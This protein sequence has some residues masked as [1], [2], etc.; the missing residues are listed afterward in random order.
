MIYFDNA[1]T[2][3]PH[4]SVISAAL[5]MMK[6]DFGN[7][8]SLHRMGLIAEDELKR[9]RAVIAKEMGASASEV[10]FTSGGTEG[11]NIAILGGARAKKRLGNTVIIPAT[12]HASVENSALSLEEE[13]FLVLRIPAPGGILDIDKLYDVA[14]ESVVL[15]SAMLVNNELG[16]VNDIAAIRAVMKEKCPGAT[17]HC[18]AV[19]GFGKIRFDVK[20][21]GADIIT[22]S[23]HKMHGIR[24]VGAL[25]I[26]KGVRINPTVYGGTQE[27][28][29]RPG[30]QNMPAIAAFAESARLAFENFNGRYDNACALS[31]HIKNR[32]MERPDLFSINSL[33]KSSPYILNISTPVISE[34][35]LHYLEGFGIYV[36]VGSA[37]SSKRAAKESV[38]AKAGFGDKIYN[39]GLRI[40][41]GDYN[42]LHEADILADKLFDGAGEL[43][44]YK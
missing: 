41:F 20:K 34:V 38:L 25:Y 32:L 21:L 33:E 3:R 29:I 37:C 1:A 43:F 13:G 44:S 4:D 10:Y 9:A 16:S 23:A 7:P 28:S 24:G 31:L 26:K 18:D 14:D 35:M 42:T 8:S 30:T 12:E 40:S 36:S 19:Q 5:R 39:T 15:V 22:V 17:L 11:N 6:E 2:T 27:G